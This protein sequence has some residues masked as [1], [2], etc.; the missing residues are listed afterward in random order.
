MLRVFT[1][2]TI[3]ELD[4]IIRALFKMTTPPA[5]P[6]WVQARL[7]NSFLSRSAYYFGRSA[8][9]A[10]LPPTR[11]QMLAHVQKVNARA[12][13]ECSVLYSNPAT[14][15]AFY[16]S[17]LRSTYVL[18]PIRTHLKVT[19]AY[20][21][22]LQKHA[23]TCAAARWTKPP[24]SFYTAPLLNS[25]L[26]YDF[27][28]NALDAMY[29]NLLTHIETTVYPRRQNFRHEDMIHHCVDDC[30]ANGHIHLNHKCL[31]HAAAPKSRREPIKRLPHPQSSRAS[32]ST[33]PKGPRRQ[34]KPYQGVDGTDW[35]APERRL[36]ALK[37]ACRSSRE[38]TLGIWLN[39]VDTGCGLQAA[40]S[41]IAKDFSPVSLEKTVLEPYEHML[42]TRYSPDRSAFDWIMDELNIP[43]V[44]RSFKEFITHSH[45]QLSPT[46]IAIL[47]K[48]WTV[49]VKSPSVISINKV[50]AHVVM[51]LKYLQ[52]REFKRA[53]D[54]NY[55][56]LSY[57]Y[58][59]PPSALAVQT[60]HGRS[61]Y[62][63]KFTD[64]D[65]YEYLADV[66]QQL[67]AQVSEKFQ[68]P[69]KED[70]SNYD[71]VDLADYPIMDTLYP[72][73]LQYLL[74]ELKGLKN[75]NPQCQ[76]AR[77]VSVFMGKFFSSGAP[78]AIALLG[79]VA[80][81]VLFHVTSPKY[82]PLIIAIYFLCCGILGMSVSLWIFGSEN[83][84]RA[85]DEMID[86]F[87]DVFHSV[88]GW[89]KKSEIAPLPSDLG[90]VQIELEDKDNILNVDPRDEDES[91]YRLCHMISQD[92]MQR[93]YDS[94]S[95][96]QRKIINDTI[97]KLCL[98]LSPLEIMDLDVGSNI[99]FRR[100][101][102]ASLIRYAKTPDL[103]FKCFLL[104]QSCRFSHL[105][106]WDYYRP[107][108]PITEPRDTNNP[109]PGCSMDPDAPIT[110]P[111]LPKPQ[112]WS[113]IDS[114]I[115]H[116]Q[117]VASWLGDEMALSAWKARAQT[118][119]TMWKGL[120][121]VSSA[122]R[123]L[124]PY[125]M[126][127]VNSIS[128][129]L[130]GRTIWYH[131]SVDLEK[132]IASTR[133]LMA[134]TD[135]KI[136][137]GINPR[138]LTKEYQQ[139]CDQY[140]EMSILNSSLDPSDV[141]AKAFLIFQRDYAKFLSN[142]RTMDAQ[143]NPRV[144]PVCVHFAGPAGIGKTQC[145]ELLAKLLYM[146]GV[147][148]N[149]GL[150]QVDHARN[151]N[152]SWRDQSCVMVDEWGTFNDNE[153]RLADVKFLLN[154]VNDTPGLIEK[155]AVHEKCLYWIDNQ[156][157]FLT[158][159]AKLTT[160]K[161]LVESFSAISR[162]ISFT[163]DIECPDRVGGNFPQ[164]KHG[165]I[166]WSQFMFRVSVPGE[167]P[168]FDHVPHPTHPHVN[169]T[170]LV[171]LLAD[172]IALAAKRNTTAPEDDY[173]AAYLPPKPDAGYILPPFHDP[174]R[175]AH[176]SMGVAPRGSQ[177]ENNDEP[178]S[179]EVIIPK[180]IPHMLPD[181]L[182]DPSI[183]DSFKSFISWL[184]KCGPDAEGPPIIGTSTEIYE[185]FLQGAYPGRLYL[186][187]CTASTNFEKD[188]FRLMFPVCF[189]IGMT[190]DESLSADV[191]LDHAQR[192]KAG[193]LKCYLN[194]AS[195]YL[196]K[197]V[198]AGIDGLMDW[199]KGD[200]PSI[201]AKAKSVFSD[202]LS[203]F[204]SVFTI[205]SSFDAIGKALAI[206]KVLLYVILAFIIVL[207]IWGIVKLIPVVR[208]FFGKQSTET[209]IAPQGTSYG[210]DLRQ[211]WKQERHD[212]Q[213]NRAFGDDNDY[214]APGHRP[215][216]AM[217]KHM[218]RGAPVPQAPPDY[219][220]IARKAYV[221]IA[222]PNGHKMRC[223]GVGSRLVI[224]PHHYL[225]S[226]SSYDT[227]EVTTATKT[228]VIH[229]EKTVIYSR[230]GDDF[231]AIML[232]PSFDSFPIIA[233]RF[234]SGS[235]VPMVSGNV[236]CYITTPSDC[237]E[238]TACVNSTPAAVR[239]DD[240]NDEMESVHNPFCFEV[241]IQTQSG[242]C[243]S[244]YAVHKDAFGSRTFFGMHCAGLNKFGYANIVTEEDI[245][246]AYSFFNPE[247][248][249]V[250][251]VEP[252]G[253]ITKSPL[254]DRPL[255][256]QIPGRTA[257]YTNIFTPFEEHMTP[258]LNPDLSLQCAEELTLTAQAN[259]AI[260]A[261][262]TFVGTSAIPC[263][264][265]RQTRIVPS[266]LSYSL[267]PTSTAPAVLHKN[268]SPTGE[269]PLVLAHARL[270]P[271]KKPQFKSETMALC[272]K[273][274][275]KYL[276][277]VPR[278]KVVLTMHQ[279]IYGW[280]LLKSL[281]HTASAGMPWNAYATQRGLPTN[282]GTWIG[283]STNPQLHPELEEA[284]DAAMNALERGVI[285]DWICTEQL[286]DEVL[287]SEK[288]A[289]SKTRLYF[290]SDLVSTIVGRR[291]FGAWMNA[292]MR[293]RPAKP[294]QV[295][296][297]VGVAPDDMTVNAIYKLR[298]NGYA[299]FAG[300]QKA[301]DA[302]QQ[303]D[304]A[305][306]LAKAIND[307]YPSRETPETKLARTTYLYSMY[308][309]LCQ[310]GPIV[311]TLDYLMPSG[312]VLTTF[313]NS[314]YLEACQLYVLHKSYNEIF[315][316]QPLSPAQIKDATFGLYYG[317]DSFVA[318]PQAWKIRSPRMF[319]IFDEL[320]LEATHC[321]KGWTEDEVPADQLTFLKRLPTLNEDQVLTW[322]LPKD[323]IHDMLYWTRR[324]D[325][326]NMQV[327]HSTTLNAFVE[328][329]RYG[330]SDFLEFFELVR[331]AY[332]TAG[333]EF[334]FSDDSGQYVFS[335][336]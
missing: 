285:P 105:S 196:S 157:L 69:Q 260:P 19:L 28:N 121:D 303:W 221:E 22:Q 99:D 306:Y 193:V 323:V 100:N 37:R 232:P 95:A 153:I 273:A 227:L 169:I 62:R 287:P 6:F 317:D 12:F 87:V 230:P 118:V 96:K 247:V 333:L 83:I 199:I 15:P 135:L 86:I 17:P 327:I 64:D 130:C 226:F 292:T 160:F 94:T 40:R 200:E 55:H 53:N 54:F 272:A 59:N 122:W 294:G 332:A 109:A 257:T 189:P 318:V 66:M 229:R 30:P 98:D 251:V 214:V 158:T 311:Y 297:A 335:R 299:L 202:K 256:F 9:I 235:Q 302:H 139:I 290:A 198:G 310:V 295:S 29:S 148:R 321:I 75:K 176:A 275:L 258:A 276:P 283:T 36:R 190:R 320:G 112:H 213:A 42:A 265:S 279:A 212:R 10:P 187:E 35:S 141:A 220:S 18:P 308:H 93:F 336:L 134:A 82:R 81:G 84:V 249:N 270:T 282:K 110:D 242:D 13:D 288:I 248:K 171:T 51:C 142:V 136:T 296:T 71:E 234:I 73:D 137:A 156:V 131:K 8:H 298:D 328:M 246:D 177:E 238:L 216:A 56:T 44:F 7:I 119:S 209:V 106:S 289:V 277:A 103:R 263:H 58:V 271:P 244:L 113:P 61:K 123:W 174:M 316:D 178:D 48:N 262:A 31:F 117:A 102:Y 184:Q 25:R 104:L 179:D 47:Q 2:A 254:R 245:Y 154:N 195:E 60:R 331:D 223:I 183:N 32:S 43:Y 181:S 3:Y 97:T 78:I 309:S 315:P 231:A 255:E 267:P 268:Q 264:L 166:D 115:T 186:T 80:C 278:D 239:W 1:T 173:Y 132:A 11:K 237:R 304:I 143:I 50:R 46:D 45:Y 219:R 21:S 319:Q 201:W 24:V 334:P 90:Q 162:R 326:R 330:K 34:T 185:S 301:F 228:G 325:L 312:C 280:N 127:V 225:Y 16:H 63:P 101:L 150:A 293:G 194:D 250:L 107:S 192:K 161:S 89:F 182:N 291:L 165:H 208:N 88:V 252:Q 159:N 163:I 224:F 146:Q 5:V 322:R 274:A 152:D 38:K 164:T 313:I 197:R 240:P 281:D 72:D 144:V 111:D 149:P 305:R 133:Q 314:F 269:D 33:D 211:R 300:D 140:R 85:S 167:A 14:Q 206:L 188:C 147:L 79:I 222:T 261:G 236:T 126:L 241:P 26:H 151:F 124:L 286:K 180:I 204:R 125:M 91:A 4:E 70:S 138:V 49:Y 120:C 74:E 23:H 205:T 307:W 68:P 116:A 233:N 65:A 76:N 170:G 77:S 203:S 27:A 175:Y 128:N 67:R 145:C 52:Q 210:Q 114:I 207:V 92:D 129:K 259:L 57:L 324:K 108:D 284:V 172:A 218:R 20:A 155:A 191:C 329:R 215:T 253:P 41:L 39:M 168:N 266:V 243:G 217:I